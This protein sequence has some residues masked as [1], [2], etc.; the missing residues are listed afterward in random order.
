MSVVDFNVS[1]TLNPQI[2]NITSVKKHV[3]AAVTKCR[4]GS[5]TTT[6]QQEHQITQE[7][8]MQLIGQIKSLKESKAS[9]KQQ[10]VD[11]QNDSG[12]DNNDEE[13]VSFYHILPKFFIL[14]F[15]FSI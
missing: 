15:V 4:V 9:L 6:Q 13:S 3:R 14:F 5:R 2:D 11:L 12:K 1:I 8:L 7:Q 10:L